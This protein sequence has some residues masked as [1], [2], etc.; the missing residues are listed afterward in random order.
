MVGKTNWTRPLPHS[1][2]GC[3]PACKQV[4]FDDSE[5]CVSTTAA[6]VVAPKQAVWLETLVFAGDPLRPILRQ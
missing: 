4:V 2:N 1:P 3:Y 5:E 6:V